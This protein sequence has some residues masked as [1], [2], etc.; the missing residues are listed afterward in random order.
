MILV[1]QVLSWDRNKN[2]AVIN[3]LMGSQPSCSRCMNILLV[4]LRIVDNHCLNSFFII[5][6][7]LLHKHIT[8]NDYELLKQTLHY[9]I[10]L[11]K[12]TIRLL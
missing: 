12:E 9:T 4:L 6:S 5:F 2:V 7:D 1:I 8:E 10:R 3:R 11:C